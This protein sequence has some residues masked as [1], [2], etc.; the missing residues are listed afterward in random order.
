MPA[1][2]RLVSLMRRSARVL[3]VGL[4]MLL[5]VVVPPSLPSSSLRHL[6]YLVAC[7]VFASI[8]IATAWRAWQQGRSTR[9]G[10]L[11]MVAGMA[12]LFAHDFTEVGSPALHAPV[13]GP[14]VLQ[15][16]G[17]VAFAISGLVWSHVR[18]WRT[19]LQGVDAGIISVAVGL[20]LWVVALFHSRRDLA[21]E[22]IWLSA[23]LA[24][25]AGFAVASLGTLVLSDVQRRGKA[26]LI[27]I[28]VIALAASDVQALALSLGGSHWL[29]RSYE[30][31]TLLG[32]AMMAFAA[33]TV[34]A[35]MEAR[36]DPVS[37]RRPG[38]FESWTEFLLV[39]LAMATPPFTGFA[40]E[41]ITDSG[42][43]EAVHSAAHLAD[44]TGS[45]V[46]L[47][48]VATRMMI[49]RR[50]GISTLDR[51]IHMSRATESA[52]DAIVILDMNNS[53]L[54][55]HAGFTALYGWSAEEIVGRDLRILD[56]GDQPDVFWETVHAAVDKYG[57]WSGQVQ[58]RDKFGRIIPV[59][60]TFSAVHDDLGRLV[61]YTQVHHDLRSEMDLASVEARL[62]QEHEAHA[63][64]QSIAT[65]GLPLQDA[66]DTACRALVSQAG[67]ASAF[68]C[69]LDDRDY[70]ILAVAGS[71][72]GFIQP[73]HALPA[74]VGE[75]IAASVQAQAAVVPWPVNARGADAAPWD[76]F[77]MGNRNAEPPRI[78]YAPVHVGNVVVAVIGVCNR[79]A[80]PVADLE[81]VLPALGAFSST[82]AVQV[83][84][85]IERRVT[86][87]QQVQA[88]MSLI[89][90]HDF[91]TV[92]Q[93]IC[94]LS[95]RRAVGYEALT[96]FPATAPDVM[97][98]E[99]TA[100]G[101]GLDLEM[102]TINAALAL[103]A[104]LPAGC[105]ISLNA[106]PDLIAS[107][108]LH[109]RLVGVERDVV[110][111]LTE[112]D[113]VKHYGDLRTA[114]DALRPLARIAVDD[115][116]SGYSSLQHLVELAPD[117]IKV[118]IA[119]VRD[120][121]T[122][123]ARQAMVNAVTAFAQRIGATVVAEGIE[124]EEQRDALLAL[125]L[126]FGQGFLLGRPDPVHA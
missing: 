110:V 42:V 28:G 25:F 116:G 85:A 40:L 5:L 76:R 81:S 52:Q 6:A 2:G 80:D 69:T 32:Y 49:V 102:A 84:P 9:L 90:R 89:N 47:A 125:G 124:L 53:V 97:F 111:E 62:Y 1:S 41:L 106:S 43:S 70:E 119:L 14:L 26:A 45:A 30:F 19:F 24:T 12:L 50:T 95:T 92:F 17:Y 10:W 31:G 103:S 123:P 66:L 36:R 73:G 93:P 121:N 105:Y 113:A 67:I 72:A 100:L 77:A 33:A 29:S 20:T 83:G 7:A 114:L 65:S 51:L 61:G 4:A 79:D 8:V 57:K 39:V 23:L 108:F 11:F 88:L 37:L 13:A 120:I 122:D 107:R 27:L 91:E 15:M 63:A 59:R 115:T 44:E 117:V 78:A 56:R 22:V 55:V 74:R 87:K 86:Q 35:D 75:A 98:A 34:F 94:D 48:L 118:D 64:A 60:L 3:P 68:V 46:L 101:V 99:A 96:R 109:S 38:R 16:L 21:G 112:H 71:L 82:L 18:T 58:N 104:S 126:Q 54:E